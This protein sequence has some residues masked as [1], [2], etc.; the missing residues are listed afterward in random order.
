MPR[1]INKTK[2]TYIQN[3]GSWKE[4][5]VTGNGRIF[6]ISSDKLFQGRLV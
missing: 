1:F 4:N 3:I 6:T 5:K 2:T